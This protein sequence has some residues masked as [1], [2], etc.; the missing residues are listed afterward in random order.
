MKTSLHSQCAFPSL[1]QYLPPGILARGL[2]EWLANVSVA[3]WSGTLGDIPQCLLGSELSVSIYGMSEWTHAQMKEVRPQGGL[4]F[5]VENS[6]RTGL[7][8]DSTH[9]TLRC[10][11]GPVRSD[12]FYIHFN[13]CQSHMF[14]HSNDDFKKWFFKIFC[15][16]GENSGIPEAPFESTDHKRSYGVWLIFLS[17]RICLINTL[18]W[19]DTPRVLILCLFTLEVTALPTGSLCRLKG[20]PYGL[21][22][23]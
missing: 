3:G 22:D 13:F 4:S 15:V 6:L 2:H 23:L 17:L 21:R 10:S 19:R 12:S 8:P 1:P 11:F 16:C 18:K 5:S 9:W 14:T 20:M 7:W